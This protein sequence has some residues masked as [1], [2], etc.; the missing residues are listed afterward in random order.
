MKGQKLWKRANKVIPNGTMLFSK[1]PNL[2]LPKKWPSYFS[3]SKGCK[4]WDLDNIPYDDISL[5]GVGT[6][7]LGY[8]NNKVEKKVVNVIKDGNISTLNSVEEIHLAEK[9]ISMHSWADMARFTR[10]GERLMQ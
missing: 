10:S 8:N 6:N 3:K 1:N 4:I 7:I 5:M 2:F 9:L